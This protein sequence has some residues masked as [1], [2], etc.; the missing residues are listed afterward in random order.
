MCCRCTWDSLPDPGGSL[1]LPGPLGCAGHWIKITF[2]SLFPSLRS[3]LPDSPP[4]SGSEA[5]S[6]QQVNGKCFPKGEGWGGRKKKKKFL[7]QTPNPAS[8]PWLFRES[9][10]LCSLYQPGENR[11]LHYVGRLSV[12]KYPSA[13]AH[14]SAPGSGKGERD[15]HRRRS[16]ESTG[17]GSVLGIQNPLGGIRGR[18][19][20]VG[21]WD[22]EPAVPLVL[23]S[24][25][26]TRSGSAPLTWN[27]A[28]GS[29]HEPAILQ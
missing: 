10:W 7:I 26:G 23:P 13:F 14:C 4:D 8:T 16:W 20:I 17:T 15:R 18:R 11:R 24:A 29:S 6:P 21:R 5:Y 27:L 22:V 28:L 9:G 19:E 2:P 3:T 1:D 25:S 12:S